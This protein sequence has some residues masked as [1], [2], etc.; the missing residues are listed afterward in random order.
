[1][2]KK[3]KIA[4]FITLTIVL[5]LFYNNY[6][7][8]FS[9]K[10]WAENPKERYKI[11]S[12]LLENYNIIGL[13]KYELIELLGDDYIKNVNYFSEK[14]YNKPF[15]LNNNVVYYIGNDILEA[16]YIIF[17]MENDIVTG[18]SFGAK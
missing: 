16:M 13:K 5:L 4:F 3:Y 15:D 17:H 18:Y 14:I 10:K 9:Q 1:M 2:K 12:D 7:H 11:T 8:T 6:T